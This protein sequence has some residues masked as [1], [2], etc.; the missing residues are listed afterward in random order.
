MKK[1]VLHYFNSSLLLMG[2]DT[3]TC[4]SIIFPFIKGSLSIYVSAG[5]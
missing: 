3:A 2:H 1:S 5:Y 4:I